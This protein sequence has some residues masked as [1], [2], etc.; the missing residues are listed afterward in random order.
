MVQTFNLSLV[1]R[2]RQR[3]NKTDSAA[4]LTNRPSGIVVECQRERSQHMNRTRAMLP[5]R[6]RLK[7]AETAKRLASL[8]SGQFTGPS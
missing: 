3:A 5:L 8:L 7:D 1:V 6:A 2:P 4:H